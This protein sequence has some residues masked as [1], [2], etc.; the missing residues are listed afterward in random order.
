MSASAIKLVAKRQEDLHNGHPDYQVYAGSQ[1][2]GR[3]YQTHLTATRDQWFWGV[4]AVT[5]DTS[6]G[7]VMHGNAAGLDDAKTKLRAAFERWLIWAKSLPV[8]DL[9]HPHIA[10]ELRNMGAG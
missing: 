6:V 8:T 3:I 4:N 2:V 7:A 1:M 5:F 10:E 9:K